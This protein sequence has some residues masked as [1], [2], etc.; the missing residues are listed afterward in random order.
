MSLNRVSIILNMSD[1]IRKQKSEETPFWESK[2]GIATLAL[3]FL[4]VGFILYLISGF[5]PYK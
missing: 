4:I 1:K 5:T 3:C 2:Q